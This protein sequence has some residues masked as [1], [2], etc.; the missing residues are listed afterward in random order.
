[1]DRLL[2]PD[3]PSDRDPAPRSLYV[4]VGFC[5]GVAVGILLMVWAG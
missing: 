1:M 4:F 3:D 5:L 2:L